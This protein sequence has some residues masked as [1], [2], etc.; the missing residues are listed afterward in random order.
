MTTYSCPSLQISEHWG[1]MD[2]NGR[3][4]ANSTSEILIEGV[5]GF[6]KGN[7]DWL[8]DVQSSIVSPKTRVHIPEHPP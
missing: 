2:T 8:F 6:R 1:F 3:P 7:T 4:L 5:A